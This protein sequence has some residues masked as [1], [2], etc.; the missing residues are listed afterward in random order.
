M[1]IH[2]AIEKKVAD[3]KH[4][5]VESATSYV[6]TCVAAQAGKTPKIRAMIGAAAQ[7]DA[8]INNDLYQSLSEDQRKEYAKARV[9]VLAWK[10]NTW[11]E[12]M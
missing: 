5:A 8:E 4:K 10:L 7:L 3:R 6:N 2:P 12:R 1:A 9:Q 11:V